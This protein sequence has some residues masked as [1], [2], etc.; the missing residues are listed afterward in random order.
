M[1]KHVL[2]YLGCK[3]KVTALVIVGWISFILSQVIKD[4]VV[5]VILLAIARVLP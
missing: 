4:P 5:T 3:L 2:K 1:E